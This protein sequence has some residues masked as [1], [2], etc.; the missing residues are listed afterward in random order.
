MPVPPPFSPGPYL[1]E[2]RLFCSA[3]RTP[4]KNW[5]YCNGQLLKI[6]DNEAL[7]NLIGT[8]YGG[9]GQTSF[10]LPDLQ[11]RVPLHI[12][13][14]YPLGRKEGEEAVT[15]TQNELPKHTHTVNSNAE[16]SYTSPANNFWGYSSSNPYATLPGGLTL[17]AASISSYGSGNAHENRIPFLVINYI[18]ALVGKYPTVTT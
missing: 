18:I 1:G 17:N 10:A 11:G 16:G 13:A 6:A 3:S 12:G 2:I 15:L 8:T 9:D 7:Y 4:P 14:N 5:A